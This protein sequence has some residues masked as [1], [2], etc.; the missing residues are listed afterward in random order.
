M[1]NLL[2]TTQGLNPLNIVYIDIILAVVYRLFNKVNYRQPLRKPLMSD[3]ELVQY[4]F[5]RLS[6]IPYPTLYRQH[7]LYLLFFSS[8][9]ERKKKGYVKSQKLIFKS[10]L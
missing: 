2:E 6:I 10:K 5:R 4:G 3:M 7:N 9:K 1:L 8:D